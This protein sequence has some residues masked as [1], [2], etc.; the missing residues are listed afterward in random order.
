MHIIN[1]KNFFKIIIIVSSEVAEL[2]VVLD[3]RLSCN[4]Q[5][6][7]LTKTEIVVSCYYRFFCQEQTH[8]IWLTVVHCFLGPDFNV[9]AFIFLTYNITGEC[10][11][12]FLVTVLV[13]H[14]KL[15]L[16]LVNLP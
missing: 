1:V 12:V 4:T 7:S 11:N 9:G 16:F 10:V 3:G 13:T 6:S 15:F 2:K 8:V 14:T 5:I